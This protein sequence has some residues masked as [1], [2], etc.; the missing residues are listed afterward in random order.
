[1]G[2][3]IFETEWNQLV[4]YL[5]ERGIIIQCFWVSENLMPANTR[6]AVF[7]SNGCTIPV[8]VGPFLVEGKYSFEAFRNEP[9]EVPPPYRLQ[10]A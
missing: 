2:F 7:R 5:T 6:R 8:E 10:P 4:S 9:K 1:M 3:L